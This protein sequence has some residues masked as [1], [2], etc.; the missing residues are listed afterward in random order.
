LSTRIV[1]QLPCARSRTSGP[2]GEPSNA[3]LPADPSPVLLEGLAPELGTLVPAGID[4]RLE[5]PVRHL[6]AVDEVA[7]Q[8]H[9]LPLRTGTKPPSRHV[10]HTTAKCPHPVKR[11]WVIEMPD[12]RSRLIGPEAFQL[13]PQLK[14]PPRVKGDQRSR[15]EGFPGGTRSSV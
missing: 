4:E 10:R 8:P 1:A 9:L 13:E 11:K 6:V 2:V 14:G 7:V 12:G 15:P 5:P 3:L